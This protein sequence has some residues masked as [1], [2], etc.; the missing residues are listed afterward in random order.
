MKK[1]IDSVKMMREIR[2]KLSEDYLKSR[3]K[4][5]RELKEKYG[6]LKKKKEVA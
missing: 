5:L 4:E 3:D 2:A 6:H 1:K